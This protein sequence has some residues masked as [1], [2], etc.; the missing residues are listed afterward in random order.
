M[1][2]KCVERD[3]ESFLCSTL[4]NPRYY[5]YVLPA[6]DEEIFGESTFWKL[7]EEPFFYSEQINSIQPGAIVATMVLDLPTFDQEPVV[8]CWGIISY[9][10]DETQYQV[11]VPPIQL[12]IVRTIDSSCIKFLNESEYGAILALKSTS[13]IEKIINVKFSR[14]DRNTQ[15]DSQNGFSNKLFRFLTAQIFVKVR[16]NVFLVKEHGSLMYC[17]IEIKTIDVDQANIKIFAR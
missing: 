4:L 10:I 1:I 8:K 14:D 6:R 7:K 11:P 17:L 9:E 16:S 15:E 2:V 13:T 5:P 3:Y 12:S